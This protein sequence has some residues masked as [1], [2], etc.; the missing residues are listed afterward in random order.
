MDSE[1]HLSGSGD[2][3]AP[4][5][6]P[7]YGRQ[8]PRQTARL[9][10]PKALATENPG[11]CV[12]LP[13][14][15][16]M[17]TRRRSTLLSPGSHYGIRKSLCQ[18]LPLPLIYWPVRIFSILRSESTTLAIQRPP[19]LAARSLNQKPK[20]INGRSPFGFIVPSQSKV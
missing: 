20:F 2:D 6:G 4:T 18:S 15:G 9:M 10:A 7:E 3:E 19:S 16:F 13:E 8:P 5:S 12:V 17:S 11:R 14:R 1:C